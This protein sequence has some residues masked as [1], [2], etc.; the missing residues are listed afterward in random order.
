MAGVERSSD[1][2]VHNL[3]QDSDGNKENNKESTLGTALLLFDLLLFDHRG[4]RGGLRSR[5]WRRIL[6]DWGIWGALLS[7]KTGGV[8]TTGAKL[9]M[10]QL[11]V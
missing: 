7:F 11:L 8:D 9:Q 2:H 10:T 5:R 4:R 6:S 1:R 3:D